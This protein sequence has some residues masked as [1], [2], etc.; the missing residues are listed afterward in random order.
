MTQRPVLGLVGQVCAGKGTVAEAFRRRGARIFNADRAVHELYG[1]TDVQAD[2]RRIF[3]T[4]VFDARGQVDRKKLAALVF[5]RPERLGELT[6]IL[7]PRVGAEVRAARTEFE[8]SAD[9]A[10]VLDAPTLFEAGRADDCDRI[11][12]VAAPLERRETWAAGRG[13]SPGEIARRERWL[14]SEKE[15]RSRCHAVI[16]NR[17]SLED[18]DRQVGELWFKWVIRDGEKEESKA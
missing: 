14:L 8:R 16:E 7:F 11:V 4:A 9:P 18:L 5:D 15:K 17:G 13:W 10:L 1:R 3:G 2:V 6:G 12:F